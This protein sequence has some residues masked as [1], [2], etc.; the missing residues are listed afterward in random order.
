MA[1]IS[2]I[3]VYCIET[4]KPS[5]KNKLRTTQINVAFFSSR[6]GNQIGFQFTL[7]L[8]ISSF[9]L[10]LAINWMKHLSWYR[11]LGNC[12]SQTIGGG[13]NNSIWLKQHTIKIAVATVV[14][15]P[16]FLLQPK[17]VNSILARNTNIAHSF[18][19]RFDVIF[20][21]FSTSFIHFLSSLLCRSVDDFIVSHPFHRKKPKMKRSHIVRTCR[22]SLESEMIWPRKMWLTHGN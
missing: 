10:F 8:L 3:S 7:D 13:K 15:L 22:F 19:I 2:F 12:H 5:S 4:N 1:K 20:Y 6:D 21:S 9:S 14:A 18:W 16:P 11:S 17:A